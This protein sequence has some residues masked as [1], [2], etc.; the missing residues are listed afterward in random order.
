MTASSDPRP[1]V[2][3][4]EIEASGKEV[5]RFILEDEGDVFH[6]VVD[7]HLGALLAAATFLGGGIRAVGGVDIPHGLLFLAFAVVRWRRDGRRGRGRAR[8]LFVCSA[9]DEQQARA[10]DAKLTPL[11]SKLGPLERR[12]HETAERRAWP[13][14]G[15]LLSTS[16]TCT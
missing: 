15:W 2:Q 13:Q 1:T 9:G 3:A 7:A 6:V 16:T 12:A 8:A 5:G 14:S 10:R 4:G 11:F